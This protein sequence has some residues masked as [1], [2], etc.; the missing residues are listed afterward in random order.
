M[1]DVRSSIAYLMTLG[2]KSW[3]T[4]TISRAMSPIRICHRFAKKSFLRV[5]NAFNLFY[6]APHKALHFPRFAEQGRGEA[7]RVEQGCRS[8]SKYLPRTFNKVR[9]LPQRKPRVLTRGAG[10]TFL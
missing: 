6:P 1:P 4:S 5:L 7:K 9:G 10:F 2:M 8:A 3:R